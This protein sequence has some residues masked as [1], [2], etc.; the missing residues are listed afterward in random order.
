[1]DR[2]LA[3]VC[4]AISSGREYYGRELDI[5]LVKRARGSRREVLLEIGEKAPRLLR[6]EHIVELA[7]DFARLDDALRAAGAD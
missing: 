7:A 3:A 1:M 6:N 2:T 5:L 4:A